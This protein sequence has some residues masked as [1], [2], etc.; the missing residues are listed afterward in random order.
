MAS[1]IASRKT[2]TTVGSL[3]SLTSWVTGHSLF[4]RADWV[5]AFIRHLE[6]TGFVNV[7]VYDGSSLAQLAPITSRRVN[8]IYCVY[9]GV[10]AAA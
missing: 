8:A 3:T 2:A 7:D 6:L 1:A 9:R 4:A 5:D 10:S